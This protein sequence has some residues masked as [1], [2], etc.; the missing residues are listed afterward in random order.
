M[1]NRTD[2]LTAYGLLCTAAAH[3]EKAAE[4]L[5]DADHE[6]ERDAACACIVAQSTANRLWREIETDEKKQ[7]AN[8]TK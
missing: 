1:K 8:G 6:A 2:I 4:L 3:A 7:Q 5:S